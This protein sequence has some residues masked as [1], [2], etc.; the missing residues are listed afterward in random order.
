MIHSEIVAGA[1]LRLYRTEVD[2][3]KQTQTMINYNDK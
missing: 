3:P 2:W 1:V